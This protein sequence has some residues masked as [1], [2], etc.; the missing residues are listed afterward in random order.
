MEENSKD[1]GAHVKIQVLMNHVDVS[2]HDGRRKDVS[3]VLI[4]ICFGIF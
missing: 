3:N 1:T 2:C 4:P